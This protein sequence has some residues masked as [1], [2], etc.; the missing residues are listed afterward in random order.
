[1]RVIAD[2]HLH[3]KYSRATSRE[4]DV[5]TLARWAEIKGVTI[6][7]T[8]DFT[9]P[10]YFAEL[11][12]KLEPAEPGLLKL[13]K[14][15][16]STRFL[17]TVE[18]SNV[19]SQGGRLRRIH[20]LLFAP[21]L[22]VAQKINQA[23]GRMGKLSADGRP[24][25]GFSARDLVK[26]VLDISADCVC[27]PAHAWT[28][29][30][31]V[32]GANSGFD[33]IEE[34]YG[35]QAASIF[36]IETGLSS[37]PPM[38]WR[39]SALDRICL[40]SNSDAHSPSRIARECNVF[41]CG[42]SYAAIVD[43][44]RTRNPARFLFTVEFFPEEGKYH[45]DGHRSCHVLYTP[46]ETRKAKGLCPVCGK[47]LTVGVM[48]RVEALAD[49][50]EGYRPLRAIPGLRLVPLAEIVAEALGIGVETASV[51]NEYQR[52]VAAGG[53]ELVILLDRTDDE[54]TRFCP[55]RVLE[56]ILRVRRGQV[57]IVPGYD[58]VYGKISLFGDEGP[59]ETRSEQM[60][61]F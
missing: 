35:D 37:D 24:T 28:P 44:I 9:H 2:L 13:I 3:S 58:G 61:L 18:I 29:W 54:L 41:E 32:F 7:G 17:L 8:G 12:A 25:F 46:A 42:L 50:P 14:G 33:S 6:L 47:R 48:H 40:I 23:L 4:M 21:S 5:E 11:R 27:V 16:G 22:E 60:A 52:L 57:K 20:T 45:Y 53:S 49:R 43:A 55:P 51:E 59:V 15:E 30:H 36:A 39:W 56:G 31:S 34:C 10:A 38:N 19:Y 26:L 1:M